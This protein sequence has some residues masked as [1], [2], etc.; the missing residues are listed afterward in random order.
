MG[1]SAH[2]GLKLTSSKLFCLQYSYP[3]PRVA[4]RLP[5]ARLVNHLTHGDSIF[6]RRSMRHIAFAVLLAMLGLTALSYG[7][8]TDANLVGTVVDASGAAVPNATIEI[9][10]ASTGVK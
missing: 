5:I 2:S 9:T 4:L 10:Q 3:P 1:V 6:F 7:Q 8:A